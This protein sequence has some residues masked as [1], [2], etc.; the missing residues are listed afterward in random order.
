MSRVEEDPGNER[1]NP[2]LWQDDEEPEP[3]VAIVDMDSASQPGEQYT[4]VHRCYS[5]HEAVAWLGQHED[6]AKVE[7]GGFGVDVPEPCC[8]TSAQTRGAQHHVT[9]EEY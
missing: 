9:C 8:I 6:Q 2:F 3:P 4:V 7:R 1:A 5:E